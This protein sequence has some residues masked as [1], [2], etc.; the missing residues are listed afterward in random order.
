MVTD[1]R[2]I[3]L[4]GAQYK[5][6]ANILANRFAPVIG[7]IISCEQA[8]FIKSRQILDGPLMVKEIVD[9]FKK[10]KRSLMNFKVDFEKAFDSVSWDFFIQ[11]HEF[12][13]L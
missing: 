8:V 11:S 6:I 3:S 4:V 10:K 13:K 2:P 7:S 12:H 5:I 9:W 1:Y